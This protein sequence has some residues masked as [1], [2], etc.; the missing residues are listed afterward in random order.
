MS[1]TDREKEQLKATIDAGEPLPQ[2]YRGVLFADPHE[3][4][5]IWPGKI[6]ENLHRCIAVPVHR[7]NWR[8]LVGD[9]R[10]GGRTCGDAWPNTA[11]KLSG[12]FAARWAA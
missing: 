2:E 4:E 7:A 10:P 1:L 12:H 11:R 9:E 8:V 6:S 3:A 5:L